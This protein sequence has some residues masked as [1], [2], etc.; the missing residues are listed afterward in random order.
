MHTS[1][2]N[3][4]LLEN[5]RVLHPVSADLQ[6]QV[7]LFAVMTEKKRP[8][9]FQTGVHAEIREGILKILQREI[10][11]IIQLHPLPVTPGDV[12]GNA[13]AFFLCKAAHDRDQEFAF[14]V[15]SPDVFLLEIALH[16]VFFQGADGGKAANRASGESAVVLCDVQADLP[17]RHMLYPA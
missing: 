3:T 7:E 12:L 17:V 10:A 6:H 15:E 16:I 13:A 9:H 1:F 8:V 11:D 5:A 2:S 4:G 14:S